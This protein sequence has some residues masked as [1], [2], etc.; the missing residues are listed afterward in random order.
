MNF[1]DRFIFFVFSLFVA[2]LSIIMM[3]M[4]LRLIPRY[5]L[6]DGLGLVYQSRNGSLL[7]LIMS[8]I[9][10]AASFRLMAVLL[11]RK[12]GVDTINQRNDLGDIRISIATLQ[13]LAIKEASSVPGVREVKV[14]IRTSE[15][16]NVI[17]LR[18]IAD[19]HSSIQEMSEQ[20]QRRVKSHV[21]EIS[22]IPIHQVT[23]LVADIVNNAAEQKV[24]RVE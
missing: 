21:E 8:F 5:I 1:F 2:L 7:I 19:G 14:K 23:V 18:V 15:K 17:V 16:G 12:R 13:H 20:L 10:L 9:L 22:A 24:R 11:K 6:T 3:F 4:G